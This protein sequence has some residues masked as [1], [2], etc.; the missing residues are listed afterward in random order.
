MTDPE[1]EQREKDEVKETEHDMDP[2]RNKKQVQHKTQHR[3]FAQE[4]THVNST[5]SQRT[6]VETMC[7]DSLRA[8]E[9]RAWFTV[10]GSCCPM[11][12]AC[13]CPE[14]RA[15]ISQCRITAEF[16]CDSSKHVQ[17]VL[18]VPTRICGGGTGTWTETHREIRKQEYARILRHTIFFFSVHSPS[19]ACQTCFARP[20][21]STRC[22]ES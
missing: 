21:S 2:W 19:P 15:L 3:S 1:E 17:H 14:R 18:W 4:K 22:N 16:C 11:P 7:A 12:N 9:L 20:V 13:L 10:P 5:L 6:C 8:C